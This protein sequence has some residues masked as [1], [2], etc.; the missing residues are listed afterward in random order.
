ML[1]MLVMWCGVV[2]SDADKEYQLKAAYLLNF[3]RFVYWPEEVFEETKNKFNICVYGRNPFD[4]SLDK[5]ASKKIHNRN[6]QLIYEINSE[7]VGVCHIVFFSR[8]EKVD[9]KGFIGSLSETTLLTVSDIK[10]FVENGGMI[11]FVRVKNRIKFEISISQSD[12]S[13]IKY[14]S[15]LLEVAEQLR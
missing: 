4:T 12:K 15:Q 8:A 3:A 1:F 7:D 13:G 9:Y 6:I 10:G 5:L 11:E 2:Y 14:R